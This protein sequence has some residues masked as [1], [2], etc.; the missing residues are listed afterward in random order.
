MLDPSLNKMGMHLRPMVYNGMDH[1]ASFTKR[2]KLDRRALKKFIVG[3]NVMDD[4]VKDLVVHF[5]IQIEVILEQF[6]HFSMLILHPHKSFSKNKSLIN[7][8]T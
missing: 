7:L 6:L 2:K 5:G 8:L 1:I 4:L 3:S